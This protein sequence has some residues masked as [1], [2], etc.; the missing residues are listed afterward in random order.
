METDLLNK[1]FG[2]KSQMYIR[3]FWCFGESPNF[4]KN[5]KCT[6]EEKL[7]SVPE[8]VYLHTFKT[9]LGIYIIQE[10]RDS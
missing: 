10:S 3:I 5:T 9:S 7:E 6:K 8:T 1:L 4:L 2:T